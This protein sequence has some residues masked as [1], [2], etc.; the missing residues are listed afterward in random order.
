M[1]LFYDEEMEDANGLPGYRYS[2]TNHTFA[3]QSLVPGNECYCVEGTCAPTG[4][5][6][7]LPY[8]GVISQTGL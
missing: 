8:F 4:N 7:Y 1:S 3:N 6:A 2:A 5:D